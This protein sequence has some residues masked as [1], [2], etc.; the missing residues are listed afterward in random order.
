MANLTKKIEELS[1]KYAQ[2]VNKIFPD[3]EPIVLLY[4]SSVEGVEN[5]DL[6]VCTIL[7]NYNREDEKKIKDITVKFHFDNNMKIDNEVPF[8]SKAIYSYFDIEKML[9]KPPFQ[10]FRRKFYIPEIEKSEEFL[11]SIN[12]KYRLL[13]YVLT[14]N[15]IVISGNKKI[16]ET[17][18]DRAWDV[19]IRVMF[20]YTANRF[21]TISQF[22]DN[23]C[24]NPFTG[25]EGEDFLGYKKEYKNLYEHLLKYTK[26]HFE[27]NVEMGNMIKNQNKYCCEETWIKKSILIADSNNFE[28]VN[29]E[30]KEYPKMG[31]Y[32]FSENANPLGPTEKV[33]QALKQCSGYI[34]VYSDYKNIEINNDLA[35]FFKVNI[36]NIAIANGSLE[37]IYA[38][39]RF[40]DS[41]KATVIAP[42]YWGYSAGLEVLGKKYKKITLNKELDYD[43]EQLDRAAKE[44]TMMFI[45]NP[46]NP[47][48]SYIYIK[49]LLKIIKENKNCHFIIDESHLLLHDNFFDETL[50]KNV[51]ELKNVSIVYSLSK[52]FSVAG[53]RVGALISNS[54][55]IEKYK[56]CQIPSSLNTMSQVIFPICL[57]DKDFVEKTRKDIHLL[58]KELEDELNKFD[59]L[60]VKPS[61][62]NFIICKIKR[63][64]TAVDLAEKLQEDGIYIRELSNSYSEINGEWIRISVNRR[65]FN[66]ILVDKLKSYHIG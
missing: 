14:A 21:V 24:K 17:Y 29:M 23:L 52:L 39:P 25:A 46:N 62:T 53:L 35:E 34:N 13:L 10:I 40:L 9:M 65:E 60:E 6:D 18:R 5:S 32:D 54:E 8:E 42:T 50:S 7:H 19:I 41:S 28:N 1:K 44:S 15:S 43:L 55:V 12:V 20:S 63:G 38:L 49:D 45:C 3:E 37:A 36:E 57:K 4:G 33:Q 27:K 31:G 47:T 58:V 64:I 66:K 61:I 16:L 56:K 26:E 59:W 48:S 30:L 22:V 11:S 51:E 2:E